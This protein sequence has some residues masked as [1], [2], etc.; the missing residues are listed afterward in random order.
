MYRPLRNSCDTADRA[1]SPEL[2][3]DESASY[4]P[5]GLAFLDQRRDVARAPVL[6]V[7]RYRGP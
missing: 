5:I 7:W 2:E 6:K 4:E 1:H 3:I